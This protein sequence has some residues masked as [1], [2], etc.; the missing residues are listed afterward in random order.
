MIMQPTDPKKIEELN[1]FA[2]DLNVF[3]L[4]ELKDIKRR[5]DLLCRIRFDVTPRMIMA[6][7]V[8]VAA[9]HQANAVLRIL[10]G[11]DPVGEASL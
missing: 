11:E 8:G 2:E 7:R 5:P 1:K 10:L 3:E 6:P 4:Q 9:H